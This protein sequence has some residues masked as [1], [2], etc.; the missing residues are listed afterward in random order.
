MLRA[1]ASAES[2]G[3]DP[4]P[5][6]SD[7][8][9]RISRSADFRAA[10]RR[11][12]LAMRIG[13][14]LALAVAGLAIAV[15]LNS[16][17][18]NSMSASA[19]QEVLPHPEPEFK[20][21]IGRTAKESTPDFPKEVQAP[22]G[23]PNV[24][25]IL[26]DDVGF[27][28][29]STFGGPIPTP[30]FDKLAA[31]GLRFNEFHTTALCSPTR[32]ALITGRNHHTAATGNIMEFATGY[33]G[34]N[35][36]MSRSV[37]T[38]GEMLRY[39]GYTTAWF[40]KN[41]NVPDWHTSRAGPFDLYPT[42]LGFDY[43]FGF[44]GGDT[45]EWHSALFENTLPYEAPEQLGPNPKHMDELLADKAIG[46]IRMQHSV[47]PQKPFFVYYATGTAH[48]PHH[49]P[50]DWIA[51]FKGQFDQGWDQVQIG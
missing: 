27:G 43:F 33:P 31:S 5:S 40:G 50:K 20:G 18:S 12:G 51:K 7:G 34:Y 11:W 30:T 14:L 15:S 38:V 41:H 22:E 10:N 36:L 1:A 45:D 3:L 39:N 35:S 23:A 6:Q 44:L 42:G 37:G 19:S 28:A 26:T 47:A 21:K 9:S 17:G 24:L 46:W 2:N 49:A 32:A 16:C 25:L 13:K 48:A 8:T 4:I 29:S